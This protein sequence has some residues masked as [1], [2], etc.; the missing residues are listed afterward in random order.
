[1]I[2]SKREL[3]FTFVAAAVDLVG[4]D[5]ERRSTSHR[6]EAELARL[7]VRCRRGGDG[8]GYAATVRVAV[9]GTVARG[10][11]AFTVALVYELEVTAVAVWPGARPVGVA[12][13]YRAA[14]HSTTTL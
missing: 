4:W 13:L 2:Q 14:V 10:K 5:P 8:A 9:V 12:L 11:L 1:M 7:V 3:S 6:G